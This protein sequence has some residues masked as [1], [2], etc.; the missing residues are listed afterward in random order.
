MARMV[1]FP[2]LPTDSSAERR[3]YEGF[4]ERPVVFLAE[5]GDEHLEDLGRWLDVGGSRARNHLIVLAATTI[6]RE[7][8]RLT[9]VT[10]R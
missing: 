1:P 9:G 5:L 3:L 6:T 4:L 10:G 7:L 8:R 2:M